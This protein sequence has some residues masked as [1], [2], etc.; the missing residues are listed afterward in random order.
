MP[1]SA[2]GVGTAGLSRR[3]HSASSAAMTARA[4]GGDRLAVGVVDEVAGGEHA[5]HVGAGGLALGDDVAVRRR[6]RRCPA[7]ISDC[8]SWPIAMNAPAIGSSRGLAGLDVAQPRAVQRAVLAGE[9]L[10][11]H[12]RA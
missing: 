12:V 5:R 6:C 9:E 10:L 2:A 3:Y 11:D 8:G 4:G 1:S 7:T